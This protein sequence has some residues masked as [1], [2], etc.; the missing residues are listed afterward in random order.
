MARD[1]T[2]K[3]IISTRKSEP[4]DKVLFESYG[5]S[6]FDLPM[7]HIKK[8]TKPEILSNLE[9]T[10]IKP[11]SVF[12]FT[13]K[14]AVLAIKETDE[15]LQRISAGIIY[16]VGEQTTQILKASGFEVYH[17]A[18]GNAISLAN[19]LIA[20]KVSS[21]I[22]FCGNMRRDELSAKLSEVDISY[23]DVIVYH[24]EPVRKIPKKLPDEA[25]YIFFMS[26]SAVEAFFRLG[27][28]HVYEESIYIAI[29]QTTLK[30]LLPQNVTTLVAREP[31][32]EAMLKQ[33]R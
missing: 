17:T 16:S 6:L 22:H 9:N 7:I 1:G 20:D 15:L 2:S 10:S 30:P 3:L 27:L 13:S 8:L 24:T 26:P 29:G 21:V 11:E 4:E 18:D 12:V 28:H 31:S 33:C 5:F 32:L 19:Q 14:N 23:Q 25:D